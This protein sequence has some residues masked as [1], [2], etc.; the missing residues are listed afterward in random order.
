MN[1]LYNFYYFTHTEYSA[2]KRQ[3]VKRIN[4]WYVKLAMSFHICLKCDLYF[5]PPI[6]KTWRKMI[7][8]L[9]YKAQNLKVGL[10][11][12]LLDFLVRNLPYFL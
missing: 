9:S 4:D 11:R 8:K 1:D 12:Y 5:Y 7:Y 10:G 6:I 2:R 3:R